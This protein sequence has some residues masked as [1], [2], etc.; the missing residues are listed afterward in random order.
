M[1]LLESTQFEM[2]RASHGQYSTYNEVWRGWDATCSADHW[3]WHQHRR[4]APDKPDKNVIV[5]DIVKESKYKLERNY[6][7]VEQKGKTWQ[8]R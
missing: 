5:I 6:L 8:K 1:F 4:H 7:N 3:S 2:S